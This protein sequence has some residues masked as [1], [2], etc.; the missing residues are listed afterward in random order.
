MSQADA[1]AKAWQDFQENTEESQQSAR[2]DMIS[3][4]QASPL[5]RYILAFKNT[6]MQ[7]ARLMKKA[8]SDLVNGRGDAKTNISKIIYYSTIQN[9]IFNAMQSSLF[10][11]I[12]DEDEEKE[13][14]KWERTA[15]GMVDSILGG[16]GFGG[17][18]VVAIKNTILE[19]LKQEG[20][21]WNSD[22]T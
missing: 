13:A 4:Q 10:A 11:L 17:N 2:P 3:Q 5:G 12:G 15:N 20:K 18:V 7:Y 21:D 1:E 6:P 8:F 16:L 9:F 14:Q 22:H 19:Y